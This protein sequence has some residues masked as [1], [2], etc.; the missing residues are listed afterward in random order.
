MYR[1]LSFYPSIAHVPGLLSFAVKRRSPIFHLP[2]SIVALSSLFLL[3]SSFISLLSVT[4][5][6]AATYYVDATLGKDTNPGLSEATAW[7]TIAKVNAS[8]FLP[9]DSILLNKGETWRETLTIPSS[10]SAG[11][12]IKFGTYGEGAHP[13]ISGSDLIT[14]GW[15]EDSTC[16]WKTTVTTQ[17]NIVYFN[18]TRGTLVAAKANITAEFNWFWASNVLY[19]WSPPNSD[20]GTYYTNPGIEVGNR[21]RVAQTNNQ[22]YITFDGLTFRDANEI[23]DNVINVG[24]TSVTGIVMQNCTIERGVAVGIELK[25]ST[26]A[27]SVTI[28]TCTIQNNGT[29]GILVDY[30]YTTATISNNVIMGNGLRS[31]TD[32]NEYSGI[33]GLLGNINIFRNTIYG[34]T[35]NG[36][37]D[38]GNLGTYCHAIYVHASTVASNIYSNIIHDNAYGDGV[39][40]RGSANVYWNNIYRNAGSG[41]EFGGNGATNVVYQAYGNIIYNNNSDGQNDGIV[42]QAKGAGTIGLVIE[43]N[44]IYQNGSTNQQEVKVADDVTSL[45]MKNN[46]IYAT[47]TR[48]SFWAVSQS[49][50]V[51]INYNLHWRADGDPSIYYNGAQKTWVQWQALGYDTHGVN[52]D[53]LLA[54][55]STSDFSLQSTSPCINAGTDVGLSLDIQGWQVPYGAAPDIGAYEWWPPLL[56]APRNFRIGPK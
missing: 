9:G 14:A 16:I 4:P 42:E 23:A 6:Y 45:M 18:G 7:K 28:N 10:G 54:S 20:P 8:R 17:P 2:S 12:I 22:S 41:I 1:F 11:N 49:G 39:K 35:P 27:A 29:W 24:S 32:N 44:T 53:P 3:L 37:K 15:A 56:S 19:V 50:T 43:N 21:G 46:I 48:R 25:G 26:T 33:E 5:L 40:V 13:I 34:N 30:A 47:A 36:C 31:V 55:A 52:G 38:G 51:A